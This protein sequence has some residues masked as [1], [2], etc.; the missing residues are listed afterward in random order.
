MKP[1][2]V[3]G[4]ALWGD[5]YRERFLRWN[6]RSLLAP[7]NIPAL[8]KAV[9]VT[10]LV[11]TTPQDWQVVTANPVIEALRRSASVE[12][13]EVPAF[14][15]GADKYKR[16]SQC[17]DV[18]LEFARSRDGWLFV[19]NPDSVYADGALFSAVKHIEN[20]SECVM[21]TAVSVDEKMFIEW[22]GDKFKEADGLAVSIP[23]RSLMEGILKTRHYEERAR[24]WDCDDFNVHPSQVH[25]PVNSVGMVTRT[26]H[27]CPLI[28]KP[29][30]TRF[31]LESTYD[32][33]YLRQAGVLPENLS[34]FL[35][36]DEFLCAHMVGTDYQPIYTLHRPA[37]I[38]DYGAW[39]SRMADRYH[40]QHMRNAL[41]FHA[42]DID[43]KEWNPVIRRSE[44][45][46]RRSQL[47]A[48]FASSIARS[49][50]FRS[51]IPRFGGFALRR[52]TRLAGALKSAVGCA[53]RK[54]R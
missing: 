22:Y 54:L 8:S 41:L 36:S 26:A 49:L 33:S 3:V 53:V 44:S 34:Y 52:T 21:A 40:R 16:L 31:A 29:R 37:T 25:W 10:L 7:G 13:A 32:D 38:W 17:H 50:P 20:R 2:L 43:P 48:P 19:T 27:M 24:A 6:A 14:A 4:L 15:E 23:P 47:V 45:I 46:V 35:D 51:V 11:V 30:Q 42:A 28:I 12:F 18:A 39:I 5:A 9:D 1:H